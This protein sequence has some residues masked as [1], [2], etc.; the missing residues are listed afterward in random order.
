MQTAAVPDRCP[1]VLHLHHAQDGWLARVR[2][3]GGRIGRDGLHAV[4]GLGGAAIDCSSRASLQLRG[5]SPDHGDV[6]A[7]VLA[8][9]GL[10][11]SASHERVRNIIQSPVAGR[12]PASL[13]RTDPVV[14]ALDAAVC[15]EPG[16]ARLSGRFLFA[17]DDGSATLDSSRADL[18]LTAVPSGERLRLVVGTL[19]TD[20]TAA[21]PD[22]AALVIAAAAAFV[23]GRPDTTGVRSLSDRGRSL[24]AA[25][26]ATVI[27][28]SSARPPQLSPGARRQR[29][30]RVAVTATVPLGRLT[31]Q[32][33]RGLGSLADEHGT[34]VRFSTAR[35]ATLVDLEPAAVP[36]VIDALDALGLVPRP[37]GWHQ[38]SACAGTGACAKA[39]FD[40]RAGARAWGA[41][42]PPSAPREHW[43][44]CPRRCGHPL[45]EAVSV[46]AHGPGELRVSGP[47]PPGRA[48]P[49]LSTE[50]I[51]QVR[52][53][54]ATAGLDPVRVIG[55]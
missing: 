43:S 13:V 55:A 15:A 30:D 44:G 5:L 17:I 28:R 39:L 10:L 1:G 20:L 24:V 31:A 40:V 37:S 25:L 35:T 3:P 54:V 41:R 48:W 7:S 46:T 52:D 16:L 18:S 22:A 53:V 6:Y 11:P 12:D 29:D 19:I 4:A 33:A 2:L 26:G 14:T 47:G 49:A 42:R 32:A 50:S 21:P 51:E 38:L 45:G 23:T 27:G 36:A 8:A 34:D 9:A